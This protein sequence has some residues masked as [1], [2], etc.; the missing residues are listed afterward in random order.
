MLSELLGRR[1]AV[2]SD[3]TLNGIAKPVNGSEVLSSYALYWE[4][5]SSKVR[6]VMDRNVKVVHFRILH[7]HLMIRHGS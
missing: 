7:L 5:R 2:V 6:V 4:R 3:W 1:G